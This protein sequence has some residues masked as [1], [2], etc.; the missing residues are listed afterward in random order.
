MT[1]IRRSILAI[2]VSYSAVFAG[3]TKTTTIVEVQPPSTGKIEGSV[4]LEEM[5]CTPSASSAGVTVNLLGTTYSAITDSVGDFILDSIPA[6]YYTIHF[7]KPGFEEYYDGPFPFIGAGTDI[8]SKGLEIARIRN[9]KITLPSVTVTRNILISPSE[10]D[11]TFWCVDTPT[12]VDSSGIDRSRNVAL[13]Y[14]IG[15]E[16]TV[17]YADRNSWFTYNSGSNGAYLQVGPPKNHSGDTLY[18]VAYASTCNG[19]NMYNYYSGDTLKTIF[20]GLGPHRT[21]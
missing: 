9:W 4:Q 11:T 16:P 18:M 21:W 7:S 2:L 13:Y 8:Y 19:M 15:R 10:P 14:Y 12:V 20:T 3:C 6:G 17:N 5:D 1:K